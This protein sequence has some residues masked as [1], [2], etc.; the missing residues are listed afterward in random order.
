M[1]LIGPY[2]R[3]GE[4]SPCIGEL[5]ARKLIRGTWVTGTHA[6]LTEQEYEDN[7]YSILTSTDRVEVILVDDFKPVGAVAYSSVLDIH[8]GKVAAPI[9]VTLLPEY[10]GNREAAR[11][12]S[13]AIKEAVKALGC[14]KYYT[15]QHIK[16]G[17][18]VHR[19]KEVNH[20]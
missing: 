5:G 16:P 8:Y 3:H 6:G 7:A 20:G 13:L 14:I 1:N 19:L 11:L 12:V 10:I 18:A 9:T 17:V 2:F 4:T 15:V